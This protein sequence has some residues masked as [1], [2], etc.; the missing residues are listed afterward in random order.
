MRLWLLVLLLFR[1]QNNAVISNKYFVLVLFF[2]IPSF[3][4]PGLLSED[5]TELC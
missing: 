5:H 2:L 1:N 4:A 3:P